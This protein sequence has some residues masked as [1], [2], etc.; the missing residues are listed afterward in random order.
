MTWYNKRF[1]EW[2]NIWIEN[3]LKTWKKAKKYFKRPKFK[4]FFHIVHTYGRY[5]Y[6][7]YNRIG[8]ILDIRIT[9]ISW[10]DKWSSPRH[11]ESP[12]IFICLF[13]KFAFTGRFYISYYDEFGEKKN[14]DCYYWEYLLDWIY[15]QNK[16]SLRC[17]SAWTSDSKLYKRVVYGNAEDG[18]E[19]TYKPFKEVV[20]VV[21]M[22]LNK[23]GIKQL[24]EELNEKV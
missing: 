11:E 13:R 1:E 17:Y 7:C 16:K 5:P 6:A 20:P 18:S 23:Q 22:S 9:D 14:G 2:I 12:Y 4:G 15:Y 8:K 21:A 19:D 3:P 24:K 10:K